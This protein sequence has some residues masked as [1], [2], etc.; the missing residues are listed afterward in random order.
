MNITK[1]FCQEFQKESPQW[2][3][4]SRG[5]EKKKVSDGSTTSITGNC[6]VFEEG[7]E[8]PKYKGNTF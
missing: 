6:D 7:L 3:F 2:Q 1:I 5:R 4:K 8:S